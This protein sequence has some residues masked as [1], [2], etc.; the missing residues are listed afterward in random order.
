MCG[1]D[2]FRSVLRKNALGLWYWDDCLQDA[3]QF[4]QNAEFRDHEPL[5]DRSIDDVVTEDI[6]ELPLL[7]DRPMWR[8]FV[9]EQAGRTILVFKFHHCIADGPGFSQ[10]FARMVDGGEDEHDRLVQDEMA[11]RSKKARSSLSILSKLWDWWSTALSVLMVFLMNFVNLTPPI[12]S[13]DWI[14]NR[15]DSKY[16]TRKLVRTLPVHLTLVNEIRKRTG[17][18]LNDVV[19]G[20][21]TGALRKYAIEVEG[22]EQVPPVTTTVM[23][24]VRHLVLGSA[25][26]K[27][28][29]L[30]NFHSNFLLNLPCHLEN[31]L[32][33]YQN[34][35]ATM[36]FLK[37]GYQH[38]QTYH[39][40]GLLI[41]LPSDMMRSVFLL[42]SSTLTVIV[43]NVRGP[44]GVTRVFGHEVSNV[45]FAVSGATLAACVYT[46]N[47]NMQV[48]FFV[49]SGRIKQP[50]IL[51]KAFNDELL[52][53][54]A[55]EHKK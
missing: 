27:T 9:Y 48:T 39:I 54:F 41:K 17:G 11:G 7:P 42:L 21:L 44:S 33:R 32:K 4:I 35:K 8:L 30:D 19:L 6:L 28:T 15:N 29:F 43:T 16:S 3:F 46:S 49:D 50:S 52:M 45:H 1:L 36:D 23:G 55:H 53:E 22:V 34:V 18:T 2:A 12:G 40:M 51:A 38:L 37:A 47:G 20:A 10:V 14:Y 31:P 25:S 13:K 26:S 24:N 5:V